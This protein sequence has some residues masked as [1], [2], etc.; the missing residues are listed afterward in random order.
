MRKALSHVP[1]D[2]EHI[3][4]VHP[5]VGRHAFKFG[6]ENVSYLT[7]GGYDA[8]DYTGDITW[9]NTTTCEGCSRSWNLTA[10]AM[11][12][13]LNDTDISE[14]EVSTS[15]YLDLMPSAV[16][17]E[18]YNGMDLT[19]MFQTGYPYIGLNT[20]AQEVFA[21][22]INALNPDFD[23]KFT[24]PTW[25]YNNFCY[26]WNTYCYE[27]TLPDTF[28]LQ[29]EGQTYYIDLDVL[30]VDT[31]SGTTPYCDIYITSLD[32]DDMVDGPAVV[33]GDPFFSAFLPVF[34][35]DADVIGLAQS[36]H[37]IEGGSWIKNQN[38][39]DD[40]D[41]DENSQFSEELEKMMEE[42][43]Q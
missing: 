31:N 33:L 13:I 39:I 4:G 24:C 1:E 16:S 2:E 38:L 14:G 19:V 27:L 30:M 32:K 28:A 25:N 15:T 37:A 35:V 3:S 34:D 42:M 7:L 36:A 11:G 12:L 6:L 9:Y 21:E 41:E 5:T 26:W 43:V 22:R 8:N 10:S 18:T 40:D 17:N 29:I 20:D 23:H